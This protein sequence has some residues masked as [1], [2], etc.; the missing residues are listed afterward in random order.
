[1]AKHIKAL[2]RVG[3]FLSPMYVTFFFQVSSPGMLHAVFVC[4]IA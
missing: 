2:I 3:I 4:A 1:M